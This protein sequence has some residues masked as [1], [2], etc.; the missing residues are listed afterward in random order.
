MHCIAGG[1]LILY[2]VDQF[3]GI[4]VYIPSTCTSQKLCFCIFQLLL[5]QIKGVESINTICIG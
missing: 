3:D 5:D 4:S 2:L 1:D